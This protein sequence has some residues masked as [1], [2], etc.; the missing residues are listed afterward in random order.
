MSDAIA[1]FEI[2]QLIELYKQ[3]QFDFNKLVKFYDFEYINQ[4]IL[5]S[6]SGK[7]IKPVLLISI[8]KVI[9]TF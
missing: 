1:Q 2:S 7:V 8:S 5:D 4:A 9:P 3:G 6:N